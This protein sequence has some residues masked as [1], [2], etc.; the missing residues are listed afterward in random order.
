[1]AAKGGEGK[2]IKTLTPDEVKWLLKVHSMIAE[3]TQNPNLSDP[4]ALLARNRIFNY[5]SLCQDIDH[6]LIPAGIWS[7]AMV[8]PYGLWTH[9]SHND[10]VYYALLRD[11]LP[12]HA[13]EQSVDPFE[14]RAL[15]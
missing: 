11:N 13:S 1:M 6:D 9:D 7:T 10:V 3:K 12:V 15:Y 4:D 14:A 5:Y 2:P 8:S